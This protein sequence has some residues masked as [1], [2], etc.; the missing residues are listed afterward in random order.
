M[1]AYMV[2]FLDEH[3]DIIAIRVPR[4]TCRSG[5]S[6][7]LAAVF[8]IGGGGSATSVPSPVEAKNWL[9]YLRMPSSLDDQ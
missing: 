1:R 3:L 5:N 4:T 7:T 8:P 9:Y 2:V 6:R